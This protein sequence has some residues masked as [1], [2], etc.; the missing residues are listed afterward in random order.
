MEIIPRGFFQDILT[1]VER[2]E[3]LVLHGAR[4]TGKSTT[5]KWWLE[6]E[7]SRGRVGVYLDAEDPA[8]L[9]VLNAGVPSPSL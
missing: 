9:E 7:R 8:I 6:Q 2:P 4:Q 3:I 1:C 5:L